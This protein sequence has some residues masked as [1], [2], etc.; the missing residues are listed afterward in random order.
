MLVRCPN[1]SRHTNSSQAVYQ[2]HLF[3]LFPC[4]GR[5]GGLFIS[6]SKAGYLKSVKIPVQM[7]SLETLGI[8]IDFYTQHLF[9]IQKLNSL[10]KACLPY[11][12]LRGAVL[13]SLLNIFSCDLWQNSLVLLHSAQTTGNEA[14]TLPLH[15]IKAKYS[16]I[17]KYSNVLSPVNC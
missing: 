10:Y 1:I 5:R 7:F 8:T 3:G 17:S 4:L 11:L 15:R 14:L 6:F 16:M 2:Q 13:S 12:A 9:A